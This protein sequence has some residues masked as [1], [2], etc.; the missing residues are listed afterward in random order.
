M[1]S[2]ERFDLT[3]RLVTDKERRASYI[4]GKVNVLIPAQLHALRLRNE[5]TQNR[6]ASESGM[7]QSRVSAMEQPGAVNFNLE[8]LVRAAATYGVGLQVRFVPFSE[9]LAWENTFSQDHFNPI[10]IGRDAAFLNPG[11]YGDFGFQ[12]QYGDFGLRNAFDGAEISW[13]RQEI[14]AEHFTGQQ[15]V[16]AIFTLDRPQLPSNT[17]STPRPVPSE[18][19]STVT[20]VAPIGENESATMEGVV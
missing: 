2:N 17:A 16:P 7:R 9:M 13:G 12:G 8:T 18:E 19:F 15:L 5:W 10:P 4:R 6:F 20:Y 11:Q 1:P 3:S 14:S